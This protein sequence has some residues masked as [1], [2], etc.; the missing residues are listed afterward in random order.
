MAEERWWKAPGMV[1]LTSTETNT[2]FGLH[3]PGEPRAARWPRNELLARLV[4]EE[5][6]HELMRDGGEP[7]IR[8]GLRPDHRGEIRATRNLAGKEKAG[9]RCGR[10]GREGGS[11]EG[12]NRK[13]SGKNTE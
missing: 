8:G 13:N 5:A 9:K 4:G 11:Q 7:P 6:P 10:G 1:A 3:W 12:R 2:V